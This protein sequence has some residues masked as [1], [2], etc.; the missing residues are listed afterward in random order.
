MIAVADSLTL[1]YM[2]DAGAIQYLQDY[3]QQVLV[4]P[5]TL[6]ER[7]NP[8]LSQEGQEWAYTV[9][10]RENTFTSWVQVAEPKQKD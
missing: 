9:P 1:A 10:S 4:T 8:K 6:D 2:I 3:Y 7:K 5:Q